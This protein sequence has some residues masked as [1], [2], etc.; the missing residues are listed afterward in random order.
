MREQRRDDLHGFLHA[1][2][3][4]LFQRDLLVAAEIADAQNI[5]LQRLDARQ[6]GR[7]IGG[8]ERVADIAEVFD[9]EGLADLEEAADH[10]VAIGIVRGQERDLLAE[11]SETRSGPPLP[12][13]DAD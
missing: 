3:G 2:I 9:I 5:G 11:F 10:L 4:R 6:Q 13:S 1:E 8:A 7:E 12:R